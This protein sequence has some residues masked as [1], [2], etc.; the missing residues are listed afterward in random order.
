MLTMAQIYYIKELYEK[1]E[2]SLREIAKITGN[3]FTTVQKYAYMGNWSPNKLPNVSPERHKILGPY[4]PT[5]DAW[6]EA[7]A[8]MPRKQ[9]HS[10]MRVYERLRDELAYTGSYSS[11]KKYF[12]KKKYLLGLKNKSQE[13]FIPLEHPPGHAQLDFGEV[14]YSDGD[15]V[16][17]AAYELVLSFPHSNKAYAQLVP[18]QNREC[19]FEG[20]KRIFNHIGGVPCTIRFDNMST[21]VAEIHSG[22][23]RKLTD[24]FMRFSLHYRFAHEFCNPASGNEKGNVENNVG[25]IR[26]KLFVPMPSV[27]DLDEFNR[28][29]LLRCESLGERE[30]YRAGCS[31]NELWT[32]DK[33]E[34][35]SLP[36]DDYD[37]FRYEVGYVNKLGLIH[38]DTNRY[39]VSPELVGS[40]VQIKAYYDRIEIYHEGKCIV[41]HKRCYDKNR[42]IL[43]W[44]RYVPLLAKKTYAAV[45]SKVF[46]LMPQNWQE[47]LTACTARERKSA[48]SVLN[49]IVQ[50]GNSDRCS[51]ILD[52]AMRSGRTDYDSIRQCYYSLTGQAPPEPISIEAAAS[53]TLPL[54]DL[55][56][57]NVLTKGGEI[58]ER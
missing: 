5:V 27:S 15:G 25:Y 29:L 35:L 45:N 46:K 44:T 23:E 40:K 19:L 1:Q 57:Y 33:N 7:D 30:H 37:V 39:S 56:V 51:E 8:K 18:S 22:H 43:D 32:D 54:P 9:R 28:D 34:L 41:K 16:R 50:S 49:D 24:D 53:K 2:K 14:L 52:T 13:G 47:Y 4:I 31:V 6:L 11:V 38:L 58:N 3:S 26:R 21:A 17:I 10:A 48:L 20:M 36:E 55:S 42:D 12:R